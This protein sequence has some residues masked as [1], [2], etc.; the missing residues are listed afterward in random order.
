MK[1]FSRVFS[2]TSAAVISL[3][4]VLTLGFSSVASAATLTCTWTGTAGDNKF[5]TATNWT[6]CGG[7][8]PL[9][10]DIIRF[11]TLLDNDV[12]LTNDLGVNL[13][14]EVSVA[15]P[16]EFKDGVYKVDKLDSVASVALIDGHSGIGKTQGIFHGLA[17][18][19]VGDAV[20]IKRGDGQTFAY[21]VVD[22]KIQ[23]VDDV[24]M[25][26][27]LVSADTAKPGLNLIT[28]AGDQIPGTFNLKQRVVVRAVQG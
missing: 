1:N 6:N 11:A 2:G 9:A 26:R 21:T 5:S 18:L 14:G 17:T 23:N 8:A 20:S 13:G 19:V 28:C 4:S 7:G 22:V 3:S 16:S 27:L 12:S 24:D 10:G 15:Q 25:G